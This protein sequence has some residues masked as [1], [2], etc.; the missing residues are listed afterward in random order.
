[1]F[2]SCVLSMFSL[3]LMIIGSGCMLTDALGKPIDYITNV[4]L[5][6]ILADSNSMATND[7]F[8]DKLYMIVSA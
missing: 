6:L 5:D 7:N 4:I 8:L 2:Q 1:M 3:L